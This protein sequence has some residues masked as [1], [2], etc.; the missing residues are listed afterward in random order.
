MKHVLLDGMVWQM[1]D[2][3]FMRLAQELKKNGSVKDME[4]YGRVVIGRLYQT[5]EVVRAAEDGG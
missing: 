1:S 5:D 4:A 3:N 2:K